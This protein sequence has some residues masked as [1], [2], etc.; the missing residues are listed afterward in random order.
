MS[1][2]SNVP[3]IR[4]AEF[5]GEWDSV[6]IASVLAEIKRPVE[7]M[8]NESY[9]LVTVKRRNE[10]VVPRAVLKGK[11]ILV[12]NY[13]SVKAGDY[14]IS[15]RQ[16]VHGAN[17]IVPNGLDGAVVSNEYLVVTDSNDITANFWTVAS[18]RPE[19]HRL[20]FISSYGVDIEKL[21][22][23]VADWKNRTI[24]I[25]KVA[26]QKNITDYFQKLDNLISQQQQKHDKLS[27]IK[28]AMQEKMFPKKGETV[29]EIRFKGFGEEWEEICLGD[30][31]N[32]FSGGTPLVG[33]EE[34]YKG[35]IPFIRS[36]EINKANT[37]L[38]IS[39]L[40]LKNSSA[41][42]I[43]VGTVLY[44]LYGATSGE[45]GRARLSGAINQAILAIVPKSALC[46]EFLSH[47]LRKS[48][49]TIVNTYLQGGQGNLS[50][51]IV[52]NLM[53]KIPNIEEQIKI[54]SYF[55][56]LDTLIN[57]HQQ[58]ITKLNNIKQACLGK[59]FV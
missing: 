25:P 14:L 42:I 54:G 29:P 51:D 19:M 11:N 22:F 15:K 24:V 45:V 23:D 59:M 12:K 5:S 30:M 57:Q 56:K 55:Q 41:K 44:A 49:E 20:F 32:C 10:G 17:G 27:S 35:N 38:T 6:K 34:Y 48:K 52:K 40:G 47:W 37:E 43:E 58:Q 2:N 7:L 8:D 1:L 13:F 31:V 26:E 46:P 9:Q 3:Q 39:E 21:V 28:K 36:A 33:I 53:L 16:V 50:G 4:F 18:I